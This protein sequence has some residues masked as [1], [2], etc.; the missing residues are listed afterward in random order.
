VHSESLIWKAEDRMYFWILDLS[1]ATVVG[2]LSTLVDGHVWI[3]LQKAV[4]LYGAN[5]G[6]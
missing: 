3:L 2:L 6:E 5:L 4:V 1:D